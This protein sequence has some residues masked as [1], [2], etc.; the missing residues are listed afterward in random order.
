[1]K[2]IFD[3]RSTGLGN[4]GGSHTIV[5]SCN[6]LVELGHDVIVIDS[7]SNQHTWDKLKCKFLIAKSSSVVPNADV[8]IATGLRSV[9]Q[10]SRL[11]DRCGKKF[12][13]LRGWETWVKRN[14][15]EICRILKMSNSKILVNSKGLLD[16]VRKKCGIAATLAYSG[17]DTDKIYQTRERRITSSI[18]FGGLINFQHLTKRSDWIEK[19]AQYLESRQKFLKRRVKFAFLSSQIVPY[20]ISLLGNVC[21]SPNIEQKRDFF[22]SV[23]VWLAP[24][25]N[26]GLHLPPA[27]AASTGCCSVITNNIRNG[28]ITDYLDEKSSIISND[29]LQSFMSTVYKVVSMPESTILEL[30]KNAKKNVEEIGN[31][32]TNMTKLVEIL[33]NES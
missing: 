19:T 7:S 22:N 24:T 14:D 17:F 13:W 9:L 31:R 33:S 12:V 11:P 16:L 29:D 10:M 8:V 25:C 15:F 3:S 1:M 20:T 23:D 2:I 4:N 30:G 32:K 27:E 6:T 21:I 5:Q 26:E 28:M 18:T